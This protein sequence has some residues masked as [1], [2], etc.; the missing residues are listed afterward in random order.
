MIILLRSRGYVAHSHC[1][2]QE[3]VK[4]TKAKPK[5]K[6]KAKSD[7]KDK[8]AQKKGRDDLDKTDRLGGVIFAMFDCVS[9]SQFWY[10][11]V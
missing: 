7:E 3:D 2:H 11:G 5:A 1:S 4:K 10:V 8:W 9:S 6:P